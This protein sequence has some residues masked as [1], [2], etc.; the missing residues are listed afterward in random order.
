MS[1]PERRPLDRT[2]WM[3]LVAAFLG[4]LFDGFELGLFPLVARP[5]L[6]D[7]LGEAGSKDLGAWT[8]IIHALTQFGAACGGLAFGWFGDRVGRVRAMSASILT[9]SLFSG[10]GYVAASPGQLGAFRFIAALGMGGEWAL[11]VALVMECWPE[12]LRPYLAGIIGA[13]ANVGFVLVACVGL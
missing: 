11:G 10:L 9:Y 4:W 5:A 2:Q 6:Q 1:A 3:V 13:A 12:R 8:G 7:L